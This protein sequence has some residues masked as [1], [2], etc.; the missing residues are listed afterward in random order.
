MQVSVSVVEKSFVADLV[1][2]KY[3]FRE[4]WVLY[5]IALVLR[6]HNGIFDRGKFQGLAS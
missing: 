3:F 2:H 4:G 1:G 6:R 5:Q